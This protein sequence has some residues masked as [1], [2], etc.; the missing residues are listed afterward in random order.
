MIDSLVSTMK[1]SLTGSGKASVDTLKKLGVPLLEAYTLLVSEKEWRENGE[2]LNAIETSIAAAMP[3]LDGVIHGVP[4]AGRMKKED[5]TVEFKPIPERISR[6]VG[7]AGKWAA[8][9]KMKN[10]HKKVALIFHNY[11]AKN[12]NIGSASGLDTMESAIRLMKRMKED[13]YTIDFIPE[14]TEK[15]IELMTSHATNDI[16]MMTEKQAEECQKLSAKDYVEF[17]HTLGADAQKKM[18]EEWGKAPGDVM[19]SEK[20]ISWCPAPWMEI[21][22]LRCSRPASMAWTLPRPT[23]T[24]ILHRPISIWPSTTGSVMYGRQMR[25][26][27]WG[28]METWNGCLG[29]ASDWMKKAI[30]T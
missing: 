10:S 30:L 11:P 2:G 8:L 18:E 5:G 21:C 17:F 7:K 26:S 19:I 28:P 16:S 4:I 29:R 27:I 24:P 3:E 9:H 1:F 6:M 15:F 22:S 13:G 20:E 12:S 25:S 14:T 23:M